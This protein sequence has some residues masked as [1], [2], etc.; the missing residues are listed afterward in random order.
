MKEK[1]E[2]EVSPRLPTS[3]QILGA[4]VKSLGL[5]DHRLRS[6][7][8]QRYFS[9]RLEAIVKDSSRK[10]II[11]ATSDAL[12]TFGFQTNLKPEGETSTS[13]LTAML[14]WHAVY[15]DR[16]RTFLLPRMSRVYPSHLS[17]VWQAYLKLAII[18]LSLRIA[19]YF[20]L[21]GQ[22]VNALEFLEWARVDCRGAYLN[23]KRKSAKVSLLNFAESIGVSNNAAEAWLYRSARPS[24]EN[25]LEIATVLSSDDAPDNRE[26]VLRDLRMLY[27]ISDIS[28]IL[29]KHIGS[30]AVKEIIGRLHK[31]ATRVHRTIEESEV[32]LGLD[33]LADLAAQGAQSPIAE[34]LLM[35][36]ADQEAD[37]EWRQDLLAVGSDW[38]LRV[39]KVN[40]QLHRSEE[41]ELIEKTDGQILKRWDISNS[42]AYEHYCRSM[43]LQ[44]EG[45]LDEAV[46]EVVKAVELDP[47][48]PA[49]HFTL[50]SAKGGIGIDSNDSALIKEGLEALWIAVTLDPNWI[51]PWTEIGWLLLRSGRAIEAVAHLR[52]VR[53]ECRPL[54][55]GYYNALGMAHVQLG[56][57]AEAL[58]AFESSMKQNPNDPRI[59]AIAAVTAL[60]LGD[61]LNSNKY[62]KLARHHGL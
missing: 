31:Y 24:D 42:Q 44:M 18:D 40:F 43:E 56:E 61:T 33:D 29:G 37:T 7:T 9:G 49:N 39:L 21:S 26:E 3:G 11:E 59:A 54:D 25:I 45:R 12:A 14:E 6:K 23:E 34:P 52:N 47:L 10:E 20:H 19:A 4:L 2:S 58:A 53:P 13:A 16:M 27:W 8:T 51:L 22:P 36:L 48:D 57:F 17:N 41:N 60:Q 55:S 15:W 1:S 46:S 35:D 50:G 28:G 32:E 62:R 5:R 30:D 38:I